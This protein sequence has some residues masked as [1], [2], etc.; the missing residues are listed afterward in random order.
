M[1][2]KPPNDSTTGYVPLQKTDAEATQVFPANKRPED[3]ANCENLKFA[4]SR[5]M[6]VG[7]VSIRRHGVEF[8][9]ECWHRVDTPTKYRCRRS[10]SDSNRTVVPKQK[11]STLHLNGA[12]MHWYSLDNVDFYQEGLTLLGQHIPGIRGLSE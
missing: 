7:I 9:I 1:V 10:S 4:L 12:A 2:P 3:R 5:T 6:D 11:A 8:Q